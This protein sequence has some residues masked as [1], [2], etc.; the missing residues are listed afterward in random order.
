MNF[1]TKSAEKILDE[2]PGGIGNAIG[3]P[4]KKSWRKTPKNYLDKFLVEIST[5]L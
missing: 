3:N 1:W 2:I 5:N 4:M